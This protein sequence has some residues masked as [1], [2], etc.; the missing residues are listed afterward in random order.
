M[1]RRLVLAICAL[2]VIGGGASSALAA[3]A[4]QPVSPGDHQ[5]CLVL[6]KDDH[7]SRTQDYCVNWG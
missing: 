3:S 1:T 6:A 7:H 2:A 4:P 5:L